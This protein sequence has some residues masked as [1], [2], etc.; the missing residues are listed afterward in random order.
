MLR[1]L[2]AAVFAATLMAGSAWGATVKDVVPAGTTATNQLETTND[3]AISGSG[4]DLSDATLQIGSSVGGPLVLGDIETTGGT[5][6]LHIGSNAGTPFTG[7]NS[8]TPK[9]FTLTAESI[10]ADGS[11]GALTVGDDITALKVN[12]ALSVATTSTAG[13]LTVTGLDLF[14]VTTVS[15]DDFRTEDARKF[16]VDAHA[17][18]GEYHKMVFGEIKNVWERK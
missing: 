6:A 14:E 18:T 2:L 9:S 17:E 10:S 5:G 15:P 7:A 8:G 13:T 3:N 1:K 4:T 12:G 16:I 11:A